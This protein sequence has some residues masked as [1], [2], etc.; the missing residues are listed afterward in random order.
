MYK[1]ADKQNGLE[2]VSCQSIELEV[3]GYFNLFY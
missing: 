1:V 2:A 3:V